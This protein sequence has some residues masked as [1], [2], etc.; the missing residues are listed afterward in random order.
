MESERDMSIIE[1]EKVYIY[2][3]FEMQGISQNYVG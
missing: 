2:M 1:E 3:K